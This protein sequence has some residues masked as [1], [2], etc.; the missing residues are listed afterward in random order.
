MKD[1]N[2]MLYLVLLYDFYGEL[3]TKKQQF[4]FEMHYLNDYSLSEIGQQLDISPQ[5]VRDLLKR[6]ERILEDYDSKL[7]LVNTHLEK[8]KD[9][10]RAFQ[11]ISELIASLPTA[12]T[13]DKLDNS[14][15]K[16]KEL[17]TILES[18]LL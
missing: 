12:T 15:Q 1:V 17:R 2:R 11:I 8:R 7:L 3:L 6:T 14:L 10:E 4:A 9:T 5:A 13:H 16:L 18:T